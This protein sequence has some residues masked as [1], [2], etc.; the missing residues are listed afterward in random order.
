MG[1][2]PSRQFEIESEVGNSIPWTQIVLFLVTLLTTT[3]AGTQFQMK[4]PTE[5]SNWVYG[6]PYSLLLLA[7]LSAHEFGH[8]FAARYHGLNTTYPYFI[9]LPFFTFG[10]M[11]AVIRIK[12]PFA[13][14]KQLFDVGIAGPLAGF[15]VCLIILIVGIIIQPP[16]ESMYAIHPE[17]RSLSQLPSFG[18]YFG[19]LPLYQWLSSLITPSHG[20]L[21]P[22]NEMYH[23]PF[24]CVAW[25]GMFV[26]ALNLIPIG[27]LDGGHISYAMFGSNHAKIS[28]VVFAG[29]I[30]LGVGGF[31]G[32]ILQIF[33]GLNSPDTTYN[34]M[35]A[36][37]LPSLQ[38]IERT[39]PFFFQSWTGWL[40]WA[41]VTRFLVR[42]DHPPIEDQE[43]LSSGRQVLAVGALA[44][45]LVCFSFN[46]IYEVA[47]TPEQLKQLSK[48]PP[49]KT[50][51][52][53]EQL[54]S[55]PAPVIR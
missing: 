54:K 16:I 24:L 3:A 17:Y 26:T 43:P 35:V 12:S 18:M 19:S 5:L 20:W 29:L 23:Y 32:D 25:F 40:V 6:L 50:I 1:Y 30:L 55:N 10:T 47:I 51:V 53:N 22:L 13:T 4:D 11:G 44:I 15:L 2:T 36:L 34:D 45:F 52:M 39:I 33:R 41:V 49:S 48:P 8:Y 42:L 7:F 27:Q 9:P 21:P 31:F 46:G 38:W 37:L 28:R 14:R